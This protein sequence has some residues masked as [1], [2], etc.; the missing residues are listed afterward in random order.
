[1]KF[2]TVAALLIAVIDGKNCKPFKVTRFKDGNCKE[3]WNETTYQGP[4]FE[5]NYNTCRFDKGNGN[6]GPTHIQYICTDQ[7]IGLYLYNDANC[8]EVD[9]TE[10]FNILGKC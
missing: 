6:A 1:M 9:Q 8:K 10:G 3:Y 5:K 4:S 7:N 2:F